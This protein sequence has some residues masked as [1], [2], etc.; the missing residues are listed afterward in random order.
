MLRE[1]NAL[2]EK[3]NNNNL[4]WNCILCST[5]NVMVYPRLKAIKKT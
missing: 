4:G 1:L 3:K 5:G 2:L